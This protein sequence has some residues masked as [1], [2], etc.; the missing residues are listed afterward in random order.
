MKYSDEQT[1]FSTLCPHIAHFVQITR[2]TGGKVH[3][4]FASSCKSCIEWICA[5]M[6]HTISTVKKN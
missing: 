6:A 3:Y 2:K 4:N 1:Q 5:F